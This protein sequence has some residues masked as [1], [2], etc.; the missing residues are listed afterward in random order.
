MTD[1]AS[2]LIVED[3]H[4]QAELLKYILEAHRYTVRVTHD[5]GEGLEA[6][7]RDPPDLII[8]DIIMP[9]MDGY[10]LCRRIKADK[11]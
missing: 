10:E 3:S 9:V 1:N 7:R 5:G 8:S 4:T 6:A 11:K 2:V